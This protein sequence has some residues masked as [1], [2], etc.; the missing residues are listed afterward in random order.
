SAMLAGLAQQCS[1]WVRSR[2]F[3]LRSACPL[4]VQRPEA[5]E[6][7]PQSYDFCPAAS[8]IRSVIVS[9]CDM[10]ETWLAF[11]SIVFAPI[12]HSLAAAAWSQG[13]R[14]ASRRE[15]SVLE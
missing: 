15:P 4:H 14:K 7:T 2:H 1:L 13:H 6:Q 5:N 9:G 10:R 11:T 8:R 12:R 3:G